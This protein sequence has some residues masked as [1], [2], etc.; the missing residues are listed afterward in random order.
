MTDR[1]FIFLKNYK[2]AIIKETTVNMKKIIKTLQQITFFE[3]K[4]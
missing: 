3:K 1:R 2:N 4:I